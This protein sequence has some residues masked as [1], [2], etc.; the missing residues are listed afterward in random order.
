M[1]RSFSLG[2]RCYDM[3]CIVTKLE[4]TQLA[5]IALSVFVMNLFKIQRRILYALFQTF[6]FANVYNKQYLRFF[7]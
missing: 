3:G 4:E 1:E 6:H 5:S 7:A 2:K